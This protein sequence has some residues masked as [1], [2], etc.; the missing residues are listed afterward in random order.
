MGVGAVRIEGSWELCAH[1][2]VRIGDVAD[3][4][5]GL[6]LITRCVLICS[7]GLCQRWGLHQGHVECG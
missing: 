5:E 1:K 7:E 3:A 2:G 6:A 4:N